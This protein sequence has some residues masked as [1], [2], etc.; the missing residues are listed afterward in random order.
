MQVSSNLLSKETVPRGQSLYE[1]GIRQ[2]V[3]TEENIGKIVAIDI[4]TGEF[5]LASDHMTALNEMRKKVA[6]PYLYFLRV[7]YATPTKTGA[8][9]HRASAG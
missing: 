5:V 7:G 8:R 1:N 4:G 2:Q 9:S 6:N 3:D